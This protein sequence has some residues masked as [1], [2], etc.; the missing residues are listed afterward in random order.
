[1]SDGRVPHPSTT[2]IS[3]WRS[4]V[5]AQDGT[6][7][8]AFASFSDAAQR[9][10]GRNPVLPVDAEVARIPVLELAYYTEAGDPVEVRLEG[11][12]PFSVPLRDDGWLDVPVEGRPGAVRRVRAIDAHG[13]SVNRVLRFEPSPVELHW[14][15]WRSSDRSPPFYLRK[16]RLNR[17][18]AE[19]QCRRLGRAAGRGRVAVPTEDDGL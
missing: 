3:G 6:P 15:L 16:G 17:S 10:D 18:S 1:V 2:P 4:G 12:K 5:L 11:R 13:H 14:K 9:L 7:K 8:P 19:S